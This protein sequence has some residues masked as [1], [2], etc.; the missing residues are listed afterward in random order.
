MKVNPASGR[1]IGPPILSGCDLWRPRAAAA[2]TFFFLSYEHLT[3]HA[4]DT[5]NALITPTAQ[6]HTG[7]FTNSV[8]GVKPTK[9]PARGH[10]QRR[11]GIRTS[12]QKMAITTRRGSFPLRG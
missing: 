5:A 6:E 11:R 12:I 9:L 1:P 2:H 4:T 3:D 10:D 8:A 7:D